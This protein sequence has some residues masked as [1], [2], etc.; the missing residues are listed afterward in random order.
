MCD[1]HG[2]KLIAAL[3]TGLPILAIAAPSSGVYAD[4]DRV[5]QTAQLQSALPSLTYAIVQNGRLTHSRSFG[6]SDLEN[7]VAARRDGRYEIGSMTKQFTAACVM[8]LQQDG[9]LRLDDRLDVHLKNLPESWKPLTIRQCLAHTAGLK[10]HLV[11][12]NITRTD[13][14]KSEEII[15]KVGAMPL[16][17]TPGSAWSY[18]NT[19]YLLAAE[20]VEKVSNQ[21]IEQF[22]TERLFKPL[23]MKSTSASRPDEVIPNR[24]RPYAFDGKGYKNMPIISPTLAKGAGELVSTLDDLTIWANELMKPR[25]LKPES[26]ATMQTAFVFNNGRKAEYGAGFFLHRDQGREIVEHGGNTAGMSSEIFTVPSKKLAM[27]VLTNG[28]GY[29]PAQ[30]CRQ[31]L[32][33]MDPTWNPLLRSEVDPQP[34]RMLEL[35]VTFRKWGRGVYDMSPFSPALVSQMGT[36]R[37]LGLR[38]AFQSL[39]KQVKSFRYLD[40]ETYDGH[41][42]RR[43]A[44]NFGPVEVPMELRFD[45]NGKLVSLDQI[46]GPVP[47]DR[48]RLKVSPTQTK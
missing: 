32:G 40:G 10:D 34:R 4:V 23:G 36:V 39:G 3:L 44:L 25:V 46:H 6:Y 37:G 27:I 1:N 19:G 16:D 42:F 12:Y 28:N 30:T 17:F 43:Y 26:V 22:M 31:A 45:E 2:V 38:Q 15:K 21:K 8:L 9:K 24:A 48:S 29:A 5:M 14:V 41:E 35:M 47:I 20:V 18:S 11:S 13:P 7:R 33:V